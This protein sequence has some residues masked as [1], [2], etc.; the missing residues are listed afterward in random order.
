MAPDWTRH[1]EVLVTTFFQQE[2]VIA[3]VKHVQS[4]PRGEAARDV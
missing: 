4:K 3:V 2:A 1:N